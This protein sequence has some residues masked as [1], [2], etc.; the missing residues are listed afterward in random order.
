MWIWLIIILAVILIVLKILAHTFKNIAK[1]LTILSVIS[2]IVFVI[3]GIILF[4]DSRELSKNLFNK[5]SIFV[6]DNNG[7]ISTAFALD[8]SNKE[9]LQEGTTFLSKEEINELDSQFK[10]KNYSAMK[11]DYYKL[12]VVKRELLVNLLEEDL[13]FAGMPISEQELLDMIINEGSLDLFIEKLAEYQNIPEQITA[14]ML[15]TQFLNQ[16]KLSNDDDFRALMFMFAFFEGGLGGSKASPV[17]TIDLL[18]EYKKGNLL[19]YPEK[20][21]LSMVK[22]APLGLMRNTLIKVM[23]K[24]KDINIS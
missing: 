3:F 13:E 10:I 2:F 22:R 11:S 12:W 16:L 7:S 1:F 20:I 15:K 9:N 19:I 14:A 18:E 23:E 5:E 4:I 21:T 17:N 24:T 8:F 6:F